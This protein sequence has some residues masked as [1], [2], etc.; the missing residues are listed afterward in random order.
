LFHGGCAKLTSCRG[1]QKRTRKRERE[2]ETHT[3]WQRDL[4]L[5][6]YDT[7]INL[8]GLWAKYLLQTLFAL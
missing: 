1:A 3:D 7:E 4:N 2:R 5:V 6:L 8:H